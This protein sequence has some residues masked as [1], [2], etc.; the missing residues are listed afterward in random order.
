MNTKQVKQYH[1][2]LEEEELYELMKLKT[3]NFYEVYNE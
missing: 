1:K 2:F 3:S